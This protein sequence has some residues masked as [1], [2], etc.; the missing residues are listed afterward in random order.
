MRDFVTSICIFVL[1]FCMSCEINDSVLQDSNYAEEVAIKVN[2]FVLPTK[3][4]LFLKDYSLISSFACDS[5]DI[6]SAY[7]YKIH[8][9]DLFSPQGNYLKQIKFDREGGNG[10]IPNIQGL[11]CHT[12][13]SIWIY[14]HGIVYLTDTT[15]IVKDKIDIGNLQNEEIIVYTNYSIS[16]VYLY[17]NK[18]RKSLFYTTRII[19]RNYKLSFYVYEYF[20]ESKDVKKYELSGSDY[21]TDIWS[22]YGWKN[23]PNVTFSDDNI[24]YNYPIESNIYTIDLEDNSKHTYGGKSRY[25]KNTVHRLSKNAD[26]VNSEIHKVENVH[27]YE[28]I[29]NPVLDL[30]FRL[31]IDR[32][33]FIQNQDPQS[34]GIQFNKKDRYLMI[35]NSKFEI[36]YEGKLQPDRYSV[37]TSWCTVN[38]GLLMFVNNYYFDDSEIDEDTV[39]FDI[40]EPQI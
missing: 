1:L 30:Y 18:K 23:T 15:G 32:N 17:Y 14:N 10:I 34:I 37:I 28:I 19:Q 21:D 25:T 9:L 6:I 24:L 5:S 31:H 11:Y 39:L 33:D 35:F 29:Y 8:S 13:D 22:S 27:F 4:E 7:N 12:F 16:S 26:F 3:D 40:I 38:K 36:V 2:E 20:L